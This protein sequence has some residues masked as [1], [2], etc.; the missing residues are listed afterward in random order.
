MEKINHP[1]LL[2]HYMKK[3]NL[4]DYFSKDVSSHLNLYFW[5]K[6]E[7]ICREEENNDYL[8]FF[9]DG[10]A[11][12]YTTLKNGKSLLICFYDDFN[13]IGSLEMMDHRLSTASI[14][15]IEDSFCIG[16]KQSAVHRYLLEDVVF[17]QF[18]LR[19][20]SI[21]L[22]R[23][24]KNSSINLLYPLENRLASYLFATKEE[25]NLDISIYPIFNENLTSLA[26]LLGTSYRHLH[27]SLK[28]LADKKVINKAAHG[29]ELIDLPQLEELAAELYH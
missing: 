10:K 16:I 28:V 7:H 11:K 27:R 18:I 20:L 26:E 22:E 13:L 15:V 14:Q 3:Y 5:K 29:F 17:L 24:T 9:V 21:E 19:S 23:S 4:S 6:G 1:K 8:F 12:V 2:N 25:P